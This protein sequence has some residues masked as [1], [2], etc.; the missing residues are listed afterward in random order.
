MCPAS[1]LWHESHSLPTA[2]SSIFCSNKNS[3]EKLRVERRGDE[4]ESYK[5]SLKH[6]RERQS[7]CIF[8]KRCWAS[9]P[10]SIQSPR[11]YIFSNQRLPKHDLTLCY[12]SPRWTMTLATLLTSPHRAHFLPLWRTSG[13]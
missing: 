5:K 11:H 1:S 2:L 13:R 7:G 6:S 12:L 4:Q 10:S 3:E 8:L 9:C